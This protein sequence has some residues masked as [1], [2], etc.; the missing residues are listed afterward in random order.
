MTSIN[1]AQAIFSKFYKITPRKQVG[2]VGKVVKLF[3][4]VISGLRNYVIP[5]GKVA[6]LIRICISCVGMVVKP[7]LICI[8]RAGEVVSVIL[9]YIFSESKVVTTIE[10]LLL[11]IPLCP[12]WQGFSLRTI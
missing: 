9:I 7:I 5:F 10:Y 8:S 3:G 6:K 2:H 12:R 11:I 1:S 4:K